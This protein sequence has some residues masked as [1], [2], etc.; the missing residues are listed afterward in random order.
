MI[1]ITLNQ[2]REHH[3]CVDGWEKLLKYLGKTKAD[4]VEFPLST[5]LDNNGFD[6]ALWCLRVLP[7]TYTLYIQRFALSAARTV[8]HLMTDQRSKDALNTTERYLDGK[9][10]DLELHDAINTSY[11]AARAA[12]I[13]A[14]DASGIA[15]YDAAYAAARASGIAA[16]DAARAAYAAARAADFAV[17]AA[18]IKQLFREFC[19]NNPKVWPRMDDRYN[20]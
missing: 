7:D 4:D 15:A 10:T 8:E 5:V 9:A 2:I 12:G 3:P 1:M 20:K 19:E 17:H 6:D 11:A 16:Y 14:Y 13:A 18:D